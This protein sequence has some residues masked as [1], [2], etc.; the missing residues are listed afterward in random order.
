ME[1][2]E[3]NK[4]F[5]LYDE[6][7]EIGEITWQETP[8]NVLEVDHTFVD[9]NYRG[10]KLAQKLLEAVVEKARREDR[11]IMPVCSF[12][13]KAFKENPDYDDVLAR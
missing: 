13:V 5:A 12:A 3:E 10:Q 1:I 11:K 4:R 2:K 6:G 9:S 8:D 7:N